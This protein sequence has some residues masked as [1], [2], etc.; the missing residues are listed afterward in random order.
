M[1][2]SDW[3]SDVCSSDLHQRRA[4]QVD[5][6]RLCPGGGIEIENA[7]HVADDPGVGKGDVER[8]ISLLCGRDE[9]RDIGLDPGVDFERDDLA[10]RIRPRLRG[11]VDQ[12][13]S[14]SCRE[15]VWQ[16]G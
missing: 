4:D 5:A 11:V 10:A 2:I 6:Q 14:A 9:L 16:Y 15:R 8:A 3:S 1:R 12:I 7:A 13:G